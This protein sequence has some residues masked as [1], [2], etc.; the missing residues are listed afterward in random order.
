MDWRYLSIALLK[1][2][3]GRRQVA[4]LIRLAL[5][6]VVNVDIY[7]EA[8]LEIV[9]RLA[10]QIGLLV[11]IAMEANLPAI[12]CV[13]GIGR[14]VE[15]LGWIRLHL[16]TVDPRTALDIIAGWNALK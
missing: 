10:T 3:D 11:Q 6:Q 12:I 13:V 1:D 9:E 4:S 5:R 16:I 8:I 14:N 15:D 2:E 7:Q